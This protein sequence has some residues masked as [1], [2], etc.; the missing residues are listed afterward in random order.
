M[1]KTMQKRIGFS[2][3]GILIFVSSLSSQPYC[4]R[5]L[6]PEAK[7][8][9]LRFDSAAN[10]RKPYY[11]Q[12]DQYPARTRGTLD[13]K[14]VNKTGVNLKVYGLD[15]Y[16][17][18]GTWFTPEYREKCRRNLIAIVKAAWRK[19]QAI[20]CFSWHLENPYTPSDFNNYMGCRYRYGVK[21]YP[22]EHRYVIKEILEEQGDSCGF[23]SYGKED[24][25]TG[26]Q[27]PAVWFDA[28]CREVADIICELKDD[29]SH[30][31]PLVLRLWHEC[32]DSWQW[33]GSKYVSAEDYISFFQLT[34]N[35]I[36][37]YTGTHSILY[38][39]CPDRY[40][41]T[42]KDYM[43][44]YPGNEYVEMIGFDDYSIGTTGKALQVTIQHARM[45]SALA[46]KYKK[47]AGLFETSNSKEITSSRF[48]H[49]FLRPLIQAEHVKLGLVQLWSTDR[50]ST[51]EEIADRKQFL[52]SDIIKILNK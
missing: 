43:L 25:P 5:N 22:E 24:N 46:E 47:V 4:A 10:E 40:W 33:W 18:T 20:P 52:L 51:A 38:A 50:L 32:E 1:N 49:D 9:L 19:Y 31:I 28:R 36:E 3:I 8:W 15:F 13:S 35:K 14:Y 48:F 26:Y 23:G 21:G 11:S 30:P 7:M 17:A 44:R 37:R 27:N 39:Y 45:V 16:Y 6:I 41:K 12:F 42:E 29:V 34:V 2:M